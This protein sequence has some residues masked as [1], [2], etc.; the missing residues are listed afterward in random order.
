MVRVKRAT[1]KYEL[2]LKQS[3][4]IIYKY[5]QLLYIGALIGYFM[6]LDVWQMKKSRQIKSYADFRISA[7]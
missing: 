1:E 6:I 7:P 3:L 2:S 5:R 4:F